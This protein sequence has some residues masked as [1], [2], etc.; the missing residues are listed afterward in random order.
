[1]GYRLDFLFLYSYTFG[2]Q[3]LTFTIQPTG[4][5]TDTTIGADNTM[6]RNDNGNR[7][8]PDGRTNSTNSL[9]PPNPASNLTVTRC[10]SARNL[11]QSQPNGNL[12][13]RPDKVQRQVGVSV[14]SD[15]SQS[16]LNQRGRT[17][18]ELGAGKKF[19]HSSQ[20][21][22]PVIGEVES[23][24]AAGIRSNQQL[25]K[26]RRSKRKVDIRNV[27]HRVK[28]GIILLFL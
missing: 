24:K 1:M 3:Q 12:K 7:I 8:R 6:A 16:L 13:R 2:L 23:A 27:F 20:S 15:S 25:A 17:L 5:T 21:T 4:I 14:G 9:R 28:I 11:G 19:T 26:R 10:L 22:L 18:G